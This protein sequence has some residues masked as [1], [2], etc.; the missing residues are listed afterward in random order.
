MTARIV[1]SRRSLLTVGLALLAGGLALG[2]PRPAAAQ[3]ETHVRDIAAHVQ[4]VAGAGLIEVKTFYGDFM[5]DRAQDAISF[6]YHD[7]GHADVLTV[8]LF[9]A[10]DGRMRFVRHVPGIRGLDPRDVAIGRSVITGLTTVRGARTSFRISVREEAGAPDFAPAPP[11][12]SAPPP[13][14]VFTVDGPNADCTFPAGNGAVRIAPGSLAVEWGG[15]E[16]VFSPVQVTS[17]DAEV[18]TLRGP[19]GLTWSTRWLP[20]SKMILRG[21]LSWNGPTERTV[22]VLCQR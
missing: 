13:Y 10:I 4:R 9:E 1:S 2:Q 21:R 3:T 12:A 22:L 20:G 16:T 17:C 7:D 6:I 18:C 15:D 8:A 5:G 11:R 19:R 14:G